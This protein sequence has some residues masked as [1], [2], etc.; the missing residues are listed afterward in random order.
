MVVCFFPG[1]H[2]Q[3]NREISGLSCSDLRQVRVSEYDYCNRKSCPPP[4]ASGRLH[5]RVKKSEGQIEPPCRTSS[6]LACASLFLG[7]ELTMA[8][9]SQTDSGPS[10]SRPS[11]HGGLKAES[12]SFPLRHSLRGG[13]QDSIVLQGF[14]EKRA[15]VSTIDTPPHLLFHSLSSA[16]NCTLTAAVT[17]WAHPLLSNPIAVR[18]AGWQSAEVWKNWKRRWIVLR[19]DEDDA[20][21]SWH[22][23]ADPWSEPAGSM[24]L[25]S[26]TQLSTHSAR[27]RCLR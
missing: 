6:Q 23:S 7:V 25:L 11:S 24:P 10:L 1:T 3:T 17:Y 12:G 14:L 9:S 16:C 18:S 20:W 22:T 27:L 5:R 4:R 15:V 2:R 13:L 26:Q 19:C 21:L 8:A